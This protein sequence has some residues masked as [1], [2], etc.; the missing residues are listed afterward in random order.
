MAQEDVNAE[1]L[2]RNVGERVR[3]RPHILLDVRAHPLQ[4]E[5]NVLTSGEP[6][7]RYKTE[8]PDFEW[9]INSVDKTGVTLHCSFTGD[10]VTLGADNVRVATRN[11]GRLP[12]AYLSVSRWAT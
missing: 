11:Y 1:Y 8:K 10:T 4:M 9:T 7:Q 3:L 2:K 5:V 6:V 12:P